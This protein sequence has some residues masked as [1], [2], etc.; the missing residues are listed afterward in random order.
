M[1][2][3]IE[4]ETTEA[5]MMGATVAETAAVATAVRAEP[6]TGATG[7]QLADRL[8]P[9]AAR[10][11][12]IGWVLLLVFTALGLV[13][14][15]TWRLLI[16]ATDARMQQE[17]RFE[18]EQFAE[19]TAPGVNPRTGMPFASVDE[20]IREAIAY[21]VA[22]PNEKFLGFVDGQYRVQSRPQVDGR[23]TLAG[24]VDF[25][26]RVGSIAEPARGTYRHPQL[27]EIVYAAVPVTLTGDPA[28]G[29]IV[30][31]YLADSERG[32]ADDAARLMLIV[33]A[34]TLLG[35][36]GAAWLVAGRI[37]RPLR[38]IT[39]T[40]R[41]ITE[42][43][44]SQRIPRRGG[45]GDELGDL[46]ATVN[47]MLDRIENGI[48][49]QRRFVDDA[50]HELRTPI[51]IIRG[52]LDVLDPTDPADVSSTVGLVNDELDRMNRMVSDLL[53]LAQSEQPAF[54]HPEAVDVAA[55]TTDTFDKIALLG[56]RDFAVEA[57]ADIFAV[58]DPQRITQ[59]LVA[60][61]DNACRYTDSGDRIALGSR[62]EGGWLRFWI[63]DSG[64]GVSDEDRPRIFQRFARGGAGSRR[65]DGAGLGLAIV[66]AIAVAHGGVVLLDSTPGCGATFSVVVPLVPGSSE[67]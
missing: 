51:T 39:S 54:L 36:V 1:G 66:D 57:V 17:L 53:L 56:D 19:L 47:G 46:V 2:A 44:L 27:G 25:S 48:S 59:A 58:L 32:D 49:A 3:T 61:A 12:I 41:T 65:S 16:A 26:Q 43:D 6:T 64:P 23:A 42:T 30:A 62:V 60:L 38:D 50:G 63:T 15:V 14:F 10:T 31:A 40:A 7:R 9:S 13:T 33:G 21:N 52:H 11:R 67:R 35:A 28:R 29:V 5:A 45:D 24:D 37:L 4:V 20:V 34:V 18:M 55:L 22:R 8:R